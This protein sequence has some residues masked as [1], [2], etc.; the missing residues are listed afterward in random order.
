MFL[1]QC[2]LAPIEQQY[3]CHTIDAL[4]LV[5][6]AVQCYLHI[7]KSFGT[8]LKYSISASNLLAIYYNMIM[9]VR[10]THLSSLC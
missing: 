9:I 2:V 10:I 1:G 6:V 7:P 8:H 3:M 5:T 4:A